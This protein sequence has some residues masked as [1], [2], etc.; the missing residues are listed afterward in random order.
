[1]ASLTPKPKLKEKDEDP[2]S[3]DFE[4]RMGDEEGD[5]EDP[6]K[7]A[8]YSFQV[9]TNTIELQPGIRHGV[10]AVPSSNNLI[11]IYTLIDR[12]PQSKALSHYTTLKGHDGTINDICFCSFDPNV[13]FS[14]GSD[15]AIFAWDV[16]AK[17]KTLFFAGET[18]ITSLYTRG[19]IWNH[20]G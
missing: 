11:D 2:D 16:R 4:G 3:M 12:P 18:Q 14:C 1:M 5:E 7:D 17:Q 15:G 20:C 9:C 19:F 6:D 10:V 13:L 8:I